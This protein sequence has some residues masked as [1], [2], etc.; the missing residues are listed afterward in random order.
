MGQKKMAK[1]EKGRK[2]GIK[3]KGRKGSK[4]PPIRISGC[5]TKAYIRR[6]AVDL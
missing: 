2:N 1:R 5:A 6:Y 4:T 3:G